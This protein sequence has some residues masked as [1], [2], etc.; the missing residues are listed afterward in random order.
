MSGSLPIGASNVTV[1]PGGTSLTAYS[2]A[3]STGTTYFVTVTTPGG[4]SVYND[5][6]GV[7]TYSATTTESGDPGGFADHFGI[8]GTTAGGTGITIT[9]TGFYNGSTPATVAFTPQGGGASQAATSVKVL[10]P[11]TITATAPS[12]TS[13]GNFFPDVT[14]TTQAG[15]SATGAGDVFNYIVQYPL[16][17]TVSDAGKHCA[18]GTAYW[19]HTDHNYPGG[20]F[21]SNSTPA[22]D[23]SCRR[24]WNRRNRSDG[25]ERERD[26]RSYS[27]S[28]RSGRLLRH[29]DHDGR[30]KQLH[31]PDKQHS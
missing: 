18:N 7:F 8:E 19:W 26:N 6:G 31:Q 27:G 24:H 12:Q 1:A 17:V 4:T 28:T 20:N 3:I 5:S 14:V 11:T 23:A 21:L 30:G 16:V 10:S 15:T 29:C 22:L 13:A 2:P 9:G 25:R